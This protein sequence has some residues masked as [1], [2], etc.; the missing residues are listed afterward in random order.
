MSKQFGSNNNSVKNNINNKTVQCMD[1]SYSTIL[2]NTTLNI[3][4]NTPSAG[5]FK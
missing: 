3:S 1:T 2:N 4:G 5:C